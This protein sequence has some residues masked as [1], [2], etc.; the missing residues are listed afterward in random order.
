MTLADPGADA[1]DKQ[2][3]DEDIAFRW[4]AD[5]DAAELAYILYQVPVLMAVHAAEMLEK[6]G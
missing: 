2:Q 1:A 4:R 3:H 5:T 6:A